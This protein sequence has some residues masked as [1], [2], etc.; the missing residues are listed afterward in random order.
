MALR[1]HFHGNEHKIVVQPHNN[2]KNSSVPYLCTYKSTKIALNAELKA[3]ISAS[4][5]LF[6]GKRTSKNS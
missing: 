3:T 6:K 5:A 2:L 1:Y 4:R